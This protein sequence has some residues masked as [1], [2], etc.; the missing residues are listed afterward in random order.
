[1]ILRFAGWEPAA[2]RFPPWPPSRDATPGH[3]K[4]AVAFLSVFRAA[5]SSDGSGAGDRGQQ[6]PP[7]T[8]GH[9]EVPTARTRGPPF[10]GEPGSPQHSEGHLT[11]EAARAL[12][13]REKTKPV[14]TAEAA[15]GRHSDRAMG[16]SAS[17]PWKRTECVVVQEKLGGAD[18]S[19]AAAGP[20]AGPPA[21]WVADRAGGVGHAQRPGADGG[22]RGDRD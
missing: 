17:R 13:R 9:G 21:E 22:A 14:G 20:H 1:M 4:E 10:A 3:S 16:E 18:R 19:R 6:R 12:R 15:N 11:H 5:G 8:H 2:W 7:R